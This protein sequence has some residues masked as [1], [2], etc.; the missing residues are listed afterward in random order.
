MELISV[1]V[2]VYQVEAYL[3]QCVQS[4]VNQTYSNLQIILVDDGSPDR[5]G[6]MC[7]AWAEKDPRIQ[8]L[9]KQNGGLSDAR[10][11][12]ME[13]ATGVYTAFVDSD[14]WIAPDFIQTL[15]DAMIHSGAQIAACD[16]CLVYPGEEP[17]RTDGVRERKTYTTEEAIRDLLHGRALRTV[18]WNKLYLST[19]LE[20]ERYPVGKHHEDEFLT[21]RLC[22]KAEKLVYVDRPMY[23][24]LQRPGSIMH[25]F[26]VRRLDALEARL[27]RLEYLKEHYPALCQN[28]KF[29]LCMFCAFLYRQAQKTSD[30]SA[31][32]I[33]NMIKRLRR[34][35]SISLKD[36][37]G[38]SC[39]QILYALGTGHCMGLFCRML[40]LCSPTEDL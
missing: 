22:G 13:V 16:V 29:A 31:P 10:N 23:F 5:C 9:H 39:K 30:P 18:A 2:P 14:D 15:Y 7:E 36:Y 3:N 33:R 37:Q 25:S 12:G 8:V 24:Y 4:I 40:N 17:E 28:E 6:S 26:T 34:Q 38:A 20:G 21:Y 11:A 32:Q 35:N 19:L 27:E 1:I